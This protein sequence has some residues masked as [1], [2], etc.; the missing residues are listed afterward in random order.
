ME[1]HYGIADLT[2]FGDY[3]RGEFTAGGDV[4]RMPPLRYGFQLDYTKSAWSANLRLTRA[5][6]QDYPGRNES[7]TPGYVLLN[8]GSQYQTQGFAKTT[9]LLYV[10]GNNLLNENIRNST[11][12]LR[13]YAPEP[14]R[15]AELGIKISY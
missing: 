3:T 5:E 4:P 2:L 9:L 6:A 7:P 8:I 10:K 14:G 12:Y 1:N 15:G 11:S 13:N